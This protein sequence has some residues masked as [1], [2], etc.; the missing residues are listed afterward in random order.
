[1]K[2]PLLLLGATLTLASYSQQFQHA[3]GEYDD[4]EGNY[5]LIDSTGGYMITGYTKSYSMGGKDIYLITTDSCGNLCQSRIIGD[6]LDEEAWR[7]AA[8]A[9]GPYG[10]FGYSSSFR[11]GNPNKPD[12]YLVELNK[13]I[14]Q[15]NFGKSTGDVQIDE[16]FDA[17]RLSGGGYLG[18]GRTRSY[19]QGLSD[20]YVV[21]YNSSGVVQWS[22]ALGR[23]DHDVAYAVIQTSDGG[24][25]LCGTTGGG[26]GSNSDIY[27]IKLSSMGSVQWDKI[28]GTARNEQGYDLKQL[29]DGGYIITGYTTNS[30]SQ[31][32]SKRDV[33]LLR[34]TSNGTVSWCNAYGGT[35]LDE[36]R[37]VILD[38]TSGFT[39]IGSTQSYG[40]GLWDVYILNTNTS[41]TVQ[42]VRSYGGEENEE[43][44][45]IKQAEDDGYVA[46][47]YTET[48]SH[49]LKDVYLIRTDAGGESGCNQDSGAVTWTVSLSTTS[50]IDTTTGDSTL[51][52]GILETV[53]HLDSIICSDCDSV[54]CQRDSVDE[55]YRGWMV[56]GEGP[57]HKMLLGAFPNPVVD[58]LFIK[59][60]DAKLNR[61]EIVDAFGRTVRSEDF[62]GQSWISMDVRILP[63]G[64]YFVHASTDRGYFVKVVMKQ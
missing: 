56:L 11:P 22:R 24:F 60:S 42:W 18:V 19:G 31:P 12:F 36:G 45:D 3:I 48:W 39:V 53:V 20:V 14:S 34:V 13:S 30:Q 37:K 52:G 32:Q 54:K 55:A 25:A 26:S 10:L 33:L 63:A 16:G 17:I 47:G 41:G 46:T 40:N 27:L 49:G 4:E 51:D 58:L 7:I 6:T 2:A 29:S 8:P 5:I 64:V 62:G 1:M 21:R 38:G 44:R 23:T 61:I 15:I 57:S 43:G 28:Y 35:E 50:D 9:T 59:A